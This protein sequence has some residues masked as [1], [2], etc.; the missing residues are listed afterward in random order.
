MKKAVEGKKAPWEFWRSWGASAGTGAG[1][2]LFGRSLNSRAKDTGRR[3]EDAYGDRPPP[4]VSGLLDGGVVVVVAAAA[5][6][7]AVVVVVVVVEV[8]VVVV[9]AVV[10][11]V[12]A[13]V[14]DV[15]VYILRSLAVNT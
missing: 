9:V 4:R 2:N 8:V 1:G 10:V 6:A 7:A 14:A 13:V 15:A 3:I 5:A 12:V 11:V